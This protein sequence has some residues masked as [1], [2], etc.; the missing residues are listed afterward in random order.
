[1]TMFEYH[2]GDG[3]IMRF[4]TELPFTL[5]KVAI[6]KHHGLMKCKKIFVMEVE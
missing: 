4:F 6:D 3:T 5:L 1:M 2:F